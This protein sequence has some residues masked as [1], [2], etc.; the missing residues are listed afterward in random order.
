MEQGAGTAAQDGQAAFAP[1][2]DAAV[3]AARNLLARKGRW[4]AGLASPMLAS[5]I[6]PQPHDFI[7]HMG[8]GGGELVHLLANLAPAARIVGIDPDGAA[9]ARA[10]ARAPGRNS[11][12]GFFHAAPED[13]AQLAGPEA[14]TKIIVTLTDIHRPA[15][16]SLRLR[17]AGAVIDP[18]G[19]LFVLDYGPQRTPLMRNLRNATHALRDA[20][21]THDR[22]AIAPLLRGAGFVA[23]DEAASWPTAR[24]AVSLYR[25]RAS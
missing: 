9:I 13:V 24:G 2:Y 4:R 16:K 21:P 5:H 7:V 12:L 15:E 23:V 25:A 6:Q 14:A 1:L 20:A 3:G 10:Q 11:R 19:A 18:L 22:D 8:C 17:A